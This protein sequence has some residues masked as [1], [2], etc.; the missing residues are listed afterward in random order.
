MSAVTA[1]DILLTIMPPNTVSSRAAVLMEWSNDTALSGRN[2]TGAE[3][4]NLYNTDDT[5]NT[6]YIGLCKSLKST[7]FLSTVFICIKKPGLWWCVYLFTLSNNVWSSVTGSSISSAGLWGSCESLLSWST[8]IKEVT[9]L[10][11]ESNIRAKPRLI[12]WSNGWCACPI[13][14]DCEWACQWCCWWYSFKW[15]VLWGEIIAKPQLT[16]CKAI[17]ARI[18]NVLLKPN[19]SINRAVRGENMNSTNPV[20]LV[21]MPFTLPLFLSK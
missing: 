13:S 9:N 20:P 7:D 17:P 8:L 19:S 10:A 1:L 21:M 12:R 16:P 5:Q 14:S 6:M 4:E 15:R 11:P 3:H 2:N 18:E